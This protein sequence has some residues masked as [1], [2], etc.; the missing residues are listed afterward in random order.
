M[1]RDYSRFSETKFLHDISS[2]D[3]KNLVSERH[4]QIDRSF[5]AFYSKFNKIVEAHVPLK[6]CSIRK[7]KQ[8]TKPWITTGLRKSIK[9]KNQMFHAGD[10]EKYK[11][12]GNKITLLTRLSK[13]LC[14]NQYFETNLYNM[15][16]TWQGINS[17]INRNKR[18]DKTINALKRPCDKGIAQTPIEITNILNQHFASVGHKL[19]SKLPSSA[20]P[21]TD[22]LPAVNMSGSF[23]FIPTSPNENKFEISKTPLSKAYG[24]TSCPTRI[25]R[26]ARHII[27]QPLSIILNNSISQGAYPSILKHAKVIPIHKGDDPT[28][29]ENYR[30]ISLLSIFNRIFEKAMYNRLK[31]FLDNS[32]VLYK[33][34]YGFREKHST[35]HALLDAANQIQSNMDRRFFHVVISST[36]GKHSTLLITQSY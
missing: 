4:N 20:K 33:S 31:P 15:R 18:M 3:W 25:V 14:Y 34:Q 9:I 23:A 17:L 6:P 29:P 16:K 2:V 7:A 13:K 21:F 27:S 11:Y 22:Y 36:Y 19:A 12:Y 28:D 30:P 10:K 8:L 32:G 26:S 24:E 5:S 1:I 35:Q